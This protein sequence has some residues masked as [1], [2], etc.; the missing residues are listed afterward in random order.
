MIGVNPTVLFSSN[1]RRNLIDC[2]FLTDY[3]FRKSS[4]ERVLFTLFLHDSCTLF[5]SLDE[6]FFYSISLFSSQSYDIKG[7]Q[8]SFHSN[9]RISA[10]IDQNLN[11]CR[12]IIQH[13]IEQ[14]SR[15]VIVVVCI[16]MTWKV[17]L[18][19]FHFFAI[20]FLIDELRLTHHSFRPRAC[21][22]VLA[23]WIGTKLE[24]Q[25][26]KLFQ[27]N[28]PFYTVFDCKSLKCL[29][30]NKKCFDISPFL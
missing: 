4:F 2:S 25:S 7:C 1:R 16:Q 6:N 24:Q 9:H 21:V 19:C 30:P 27:V 29:K 15:T 8:A 11:H 20:F 22:L 18:P 26:Y 10:I 14:S 12:V 28:Q 23:I 5:N 13:S 17:G 3:I